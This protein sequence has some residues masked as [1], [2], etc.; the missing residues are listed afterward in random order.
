ML[1]HKMKKL[2]LDESLMY[3]YHLGIEYEDRYA[4]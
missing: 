3:L 4:R 1:R 2:Q